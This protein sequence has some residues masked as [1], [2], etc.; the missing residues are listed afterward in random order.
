METEGP[1]TAAAAGGGGSSTGGVS[2]SGSSAAQGAAQQQIL[3]AVLEECLVS[4]RPEVRPLC[5]R[6]P[7]RRHALLRLQPWVQAFAWLALLAGCNAVAAQG[8]WSALVLGRLVQ[9]SLFSCNY[10]ALSLP[11]ALPLALA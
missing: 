8:H 5:L 10:A 3:G 2:S 7:L 9:L 6:C 1:T 4:S 11:P